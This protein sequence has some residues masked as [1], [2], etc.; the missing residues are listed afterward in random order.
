MPRPTSIGAWKANNPSLTIEKFYQTPWT[1]ELAPNPDFIDNFTRACDEYV[2]AVTGHPH[3]LLPLS[4]WYVVADC[5]N[6]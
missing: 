5:V 4:L 3:I 1:D 6:L 2:E